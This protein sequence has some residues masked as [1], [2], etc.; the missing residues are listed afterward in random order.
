ML[1]EKKRVL[2][3]EQKSIQLEDEE[4]LNLY[5]PNRSSKSI[6]QNL[7]KLKGKK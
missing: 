5:V 4:I 2:Y 1:L 6:K 3:S 7:T